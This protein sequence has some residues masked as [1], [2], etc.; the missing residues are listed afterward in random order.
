MQRAEEHIASYLCITAVRAAD[1]VSLLDRKLQTMLLHL[2]K[3]DLPNP[4]G[5]SGAVAA[6]ALGM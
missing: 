5:C 1:T 3:E 4:G 6:H 2:Y